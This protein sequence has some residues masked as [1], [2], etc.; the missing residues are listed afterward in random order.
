MG[1]NRTETK[2]TIQV[3][4][5][6][7]SDDRAEVAQRVIKHI[8]DRTK[9]GYNVYGRDW[10]GKAGKYTKEYAKKKGVS[11]SGPVDLALSH[12]MLEAMRYFKGQSKTGQITVGYTKSSKNE[13]KAEGNI[14]G[15]YG[16]AP[17]RGKKPVGKSRPFLDILKK[18]LK[19]IL[20]DYSQEVAE[21]EQGSKAIEVKAKP[22]PE[23]KPKR[24]TGGINPFT[25]EWDE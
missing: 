5:Y 1:R 11:S 23:P 6:L 16:W 25:G 4:S 19:P 10:A 13:R 9:K 7:D 8:Q 20:D 22:K 17:G 24:K 14:L 12:K 15:T 21:D 18:D 3:P 2:L